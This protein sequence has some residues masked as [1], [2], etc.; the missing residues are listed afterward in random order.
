MFVCI[1][2]VIPVW[3]ISRKRP[4]LGCPRLWTTCFGT[5]WQYLTLCISRSCEVLTT[6]FA[7]GW[8][9]RVSAPPAGPVSEHT[10]WTQSNRARW[11]SPSLPPMRAP[12]SI[13]PL[14]VRLTM[15][16]QCSQSSGTRLA[17]AHLERRPLAARRLPG[18]GPPTRFS[19]TTPCETS[20][21]NSW[22]VSHAF[23]LFL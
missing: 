13:I 4:A 16:L 23:S 9:L 19:Q 7:S 22:K 3:T 18:Q 6:W 2:Q 12:S 15:S 17:Q 20:L 1:V 11:L 21:T 10:A 8:S 5:V 14:S